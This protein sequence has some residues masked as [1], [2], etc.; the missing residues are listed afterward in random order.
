MRHDPCSI[1]K[2]FKDI[3]F[4]S[5]IFNFI[6]ILGLLSRDS[7]TEDDAVDD[8]EDVKLSSITETETDTH[9][10]S[11]AVVEPELSD[12]SGDKTEPQSNTAKKQLL[13]VAQNYPPAVIKNT[14]HKKYRNDDDH[15]GDQQP[16]RS[17]QSSVSRGTSP[18]MDI[19][20]TINDQDTR[21]QPP[22]I[23][24]PTQQQNSYHKRRNVMKGG[25]SME[26]TSSVSSFKSSHSSWSSISSTKHGSVDEAVTPRPN[27][28]CFSKKQVMTDL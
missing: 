8:D 17:R 23:L 3:S 16:P 11:D 9:E 24:T 5:Q 4:H 28:L 12:K 25:Y 14:D 26:S 2:I 10:E 15:D 13:E 20:P 27:S 18:I 6:S 1:F 22:P 7:D 21:L 19:L